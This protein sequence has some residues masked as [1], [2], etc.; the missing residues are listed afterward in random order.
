MNKTTKITVS[1]VGGSGYAGGELLRIL[2]QHPRVSIKSVTSRQHQGKKVTLLHPNLRGFLDHLRFCS[3]D[4]LTKSDLL[5]LALPNLKAMNNLDQYLNLGQKIIDLSADFRLKDPDQ[6]VKWYQIKHPRPQYLKK[7]ICGLAEI[8]GPQI[9]KAQYV[10]CAGCEATCSI[11]SFYPLLKEKIINDREIYIDA[12]IGS[13]AAGNQPA[14]ATHHPERSGSFRSYQ[15]TGHRHTAEFLQQTQ[16]RNL[17]LSA[18]AVE[19]VRGILIT[20]QA[21]LKNTDINERD[22]RKI[23]RNYYGNQPFIRIIKERQGLYRYPEP[24]IVA[25]TNFCDI[26]FA[27]QANSRR[28]VV[29]ATIDNLVKGTAGQAVQAMN[30][31]FNFPQTTALEFQGLHPI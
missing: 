9:K 23:Y 22:L 24:K 15:P 16:A 12:K 3:I 21:R 10:S 11:L 5:F 4:Q 8:H 27:I 7:F 18:T 25:G 19:M 26:G 13:S 29:I 28:L 30:L 14:L 1:I 2:S 17:Y 31:M 6:Y 20:G